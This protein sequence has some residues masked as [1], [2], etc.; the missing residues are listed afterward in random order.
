MAL[1]G[2]GREPRDE[3]VERYTQVVHQMSGRQVPYEQREGFLGL[4]AAHHDS[5]G[6]GTI[7]HRAFDNNN[8]M[9]VA[10]EN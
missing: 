2:D 5:A 3:F 6:N 10:V 8:I 4:V 7:N 9:T 1:V